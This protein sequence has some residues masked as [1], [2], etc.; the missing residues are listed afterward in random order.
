LTNIRI[1]YNPPSE[2]ESY[3]GSRDFLTASDISCPKTSRAIIS[4]EFCQCSF[5]EGDVR[6]GMSGGG[7]H[8]AMI[9]PQ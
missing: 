5:D 2:S 1:F 8:R 6:E 9:P 7:G 3:S 4:T